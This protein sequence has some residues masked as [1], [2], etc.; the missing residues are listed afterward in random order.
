MQKLINFIKETYPHH[1]LPN[2]RK[3]YLLE[4]SEEYV[5]IATITKDTYVNLTDKYIYT[6]QSGPFIRANISTNKHVRTYL[7]NYEQPLQQ[8]VRNERKASG[9]FRRR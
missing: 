6:S 8:E 9:I 2:D 3:V 5:T 1:D 7:S 4:Q